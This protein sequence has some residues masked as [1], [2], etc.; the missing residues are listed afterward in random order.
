M[1]MVPR[2]LFIVEW[3]LVCYLL[4]S[5][6]AAVEMMVVETTICKLCSSF[7]HYLDESNNVYFDTKC[8]SHLI[9]QKAI[10]YFTAPKNAEVRSLSSIQLG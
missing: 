2:Y 1:G 7:I 6:A 9:D 5:H 8:E 10:F 4:V 3:A